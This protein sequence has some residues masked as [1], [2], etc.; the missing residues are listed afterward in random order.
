MAKIVCL[1]LDKSTAK[2]SISRFFYLYNFSHY[3]NNTDYRAGNEIP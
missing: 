2:F 1:L 3:L